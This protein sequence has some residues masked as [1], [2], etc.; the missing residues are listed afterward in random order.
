MKVDFIIVGQGIAGTSFAFELLKNNKTFVVIDK[1]NTDTASRIALGVYNPLILKWFTKSWDIDNQLDY[2]YIFYNQL[3]NFLGDNLFSDIGI[4]KFLKNPYDQN[5]W[6]TKQFRSSL[7]QYMSEDLYSINN[8]GLIH[9]KPYGLVKLAGKVN[10]QLLL[11]LFREYCINKNI[12]I[13][14]DLDYN[15]LNINS[16]SIFFQ[17]I[18][19]N[20]LIFCQGYGGLDNPY[21]NNLNFKPTKGEILTIYS[22]DLNLEKII[23]SGFLFTPIGNDYYSI[24]A[25]YDWQDMTIN[26]TVEAKTKLVDRLNSILKIKYKIINHQVGIRP[27]TFDRRPFIGEHNQYNNL[28]ILNGLGTRGVLLAPYLSKLLINS[29]YKKGTINNE[30]HINRE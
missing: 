20:K 2:F 9:Q 19:A 23:H 25:T 8:Q 26:R 11:K 15:N 17:G 16:N 22:K 27:S 30:I 5:N 12:L 4:Y 13:D 24:G 7:S 1:F 21:F 14:T 3:N 28:Y 29:I 18:E 6:L 10:V